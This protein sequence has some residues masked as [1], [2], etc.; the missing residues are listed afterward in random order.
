MGRKRDG[1][2]SPAM[3]R[4]QDSFHRIPSFS[5]LAESVGISRVYSFTSARRMSGD[6]PMGQ[7]E[8]DDP[9]EKVKQWF[10]SSAI[11]WWLASTMATVCVLLSGNA[12][13]WLWVVAGAEGYA[14]VRRFVLARVTGEQ[15]EEPATAR[16]LR[17]GARK[18]RHFVSFRFTEEAH[19]DELVAAFAALEALPSVA[20]IELGLNCSPEGLA[21]G[22]THAFLVTF[23]GVP[24]RD[25]YLSH[26]ERR[27]FWDHAAPFVADVFVLDFETAG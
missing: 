12:P 7:L 16:G 4:R 19:T 10:K 17:P 26:L 6:G 9:M 18:L 23:A 13:T 3:H 2:N 24:E 20:A 25:A 11:V 27:R 21:K 8:D 22:H 5:D 15:A 14:G 1:S